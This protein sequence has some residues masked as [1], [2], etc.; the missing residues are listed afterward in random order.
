MSKPRVLLTITILVLTASLAH[1]GKSTAPTLPCSNETSCARKCGPKNKAACLRLGRLLDGRIELNR[2]YKQDHRDSVELFT[3]ARKSLTGACKVKQPEACVLLGRLEE[4]GLGGPADVTSAEKRFSTACDK[5][6]GSGCM[7][8]GFA[9]YKGSFGGSVPK[10]AYGAFERGCAAG[11]QDSCAEVAIFTFDGV[12]TTAD[13]PGAMKMLDA[14]CAKKSTLACRTLGYAYSDGLGGTGIDVPR[15]TQYFEQACDL[16]DGSACDEL[17]AQHVNDKAKH[18]AYVEKGCRNGSSSACYQWTDQARASK[19][20]ELMNEANE[21]ACALG[22]YY[23]C[24]TIAD[25]YRRGDHGRGKDR[26]KF[27]AYLDLACEAGDDFTC[28]RRVAV[29]VPNVIWDEATQ[30]NKLDGK[31]SKKAVKKAL[32]ALDKLC[33]AENEPACKRLGAIYSQELYGVLDL[34]RARAAY[35][36]ACKLRNAGTC[37]DVN[38][39]DSRI[40][41]EKHADACDDGDLAA[42][43]KYGRESMFTSPKRAIAAL[44]KA[45]KGK[46]TSACKELAHQRHYQG[47]KTAL[48]DII[49]ACDAGDGEECAFV[50]TALDYP[51]PVRARTYHV[52]ACELGQAYSCAQLGWRHL[53]AGEDDQA[54]AFLD[55]ACSL[56]AYQDQ[57]CFEAEALREDARLRGEEKACAS[58]KTDTCRG[59]GDRLREVRP[60]DALAAYDRACTAKVGDACHAAAEMRSTGATGVAADPVRARSDAQKACDLGVIAA[61]VE[62][63]PLWEKT[64]DTKKAS[65]AWAAACHGNDVGACGRAAALLRTNKDDKAYRAVLDRG[66]MLGDSLLCDELKHPGEDPLARVAATT[67]TTTTTPVA[68]TWEPSEPYRHVPRRKK[69]LG[70]ATLH[71]GAF[72]MT[73]SDTALFPAYKGGVVGLESEGR[74]SGKLAAVALLRGSLGYDEQS[75]WSHDAA[76][77]LGASYAFGPIRSSVL[78]VAG[79]DGVGGAPDVA[80]M[81]HGVEGAWYSGWEL[82]GR[83]GLGAWSI[84]AGYAKLN[85][86]GDVDETR[87]DLALDKRRESGSTVGIGLRVT[88]YDGASSIAGFLTFSP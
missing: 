33:K 63:A 34:S 51:D 61:C 19:D 50:A 62:V 49:A 31:V 15:A 58:G 7:A 24:T 26:K 22:N 86:R 85:R 28:A 35:D 87:L 23:A 45:C 78:L 9:Y 47:D 11:H 30:A 29:D 8:L 40:A 4:Q 66:C 10:L 76:G 43:E 46:R 41:L 14:A 71:G 67:P 64:G 59:V 44:E 37:Y 81:T 27:L 75:S 16:G 72:A 65:A 42:C 55:R 20:N 2:T 1:A 38:A 32:A 60:A 88:D 52:K 18:A 6:V 73:P 36:T 77:G 57:A 82:R 17:I 3:T 21:Q 80:A 12:G 56:D 54:L 13:Q 79:H 70:R 68:E 48:D 83:T 53:D 39:I 84:G 74:S 5:K 69:G 25:Q